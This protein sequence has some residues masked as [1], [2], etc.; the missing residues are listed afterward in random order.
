[1]AGGRERTY[2][3]KEVGSMGFVL[4]IHTLQSHLSTSKI[5]ASLVKACVEVYN[6]RQ[7]K[8]LPLI[9]QLL[10]VRLSATP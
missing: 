5:S 10:S 6:R 1:M 4:E 8:A 9:R 3:K 7:K 2:K